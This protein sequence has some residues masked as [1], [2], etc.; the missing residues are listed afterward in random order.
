[1]RRGR[2][3]AC[4]TADGHLVYPAFQFARDG[5]VRPGIV[6]V[7]AVFTAA[8]VDGWTTAAW[9]T[10]PTD[11]LDGDSAVDHLVVHRAGAA[12]VQRV[13]EQARADAAALAA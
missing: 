5:A 4:R 6:D 8:G 1:M 2:L 13:L 12:A 9:L 11:V 7:V 10:T 3:L